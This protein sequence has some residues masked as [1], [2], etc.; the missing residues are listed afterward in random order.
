MPIYLFQADDIS[1][2]GCINAITRAVHAVDN[3]ASVAIDLQTKRVEVSS[4]S[5]AEDISQAIQEA[6]YVAHRLSQP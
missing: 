2:Q 6:G 5:R 1:C 3:E 4:Q